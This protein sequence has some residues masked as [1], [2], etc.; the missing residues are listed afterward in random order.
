MTESNLIMET[1]FA[2]DA[3]EW[4][5]QIPESV[6]DKAVQ[7]LDIDPNKEMKPS[8]YCPIDNSLFQN[9]VK[10]CVWKDL[11][12]V[13]HRWGMPSPTEMQTSSSKLKNHAEDIKNKLSKATKALEALEYGAIFEN[14]TMSK[15]FKVAFGMR[16]ISELVRRE[17]EGGREAFISPL[18]IKQEFESSGNWKKHYPLDDNIETAK[19]SLEKITLYI[20]RLLEDRVYKPPPRGTVKKGKDN[21]DTLLWALCHL[22]K[23]YTGETPKSFAREDG[24]ATGNI[25]PFLQL[26]LNQSSY[27]YEKTDW[28]LEKKIR[29]LKSHPT[30]G[31]LW[32][33]AKR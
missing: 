21:Y 26:T 32:Q 2:G 23:E 10:V 3:I 7:I 18:V 14:G 5:N 9:T 13:I 31:K 1:Y 25:I 19:A 20:N 27:P 30:H 28:A 11:V 29:E 17:T 22:Y 33:D 15:G 24:T 8:G 12:H 4:L 16:Q 6:I